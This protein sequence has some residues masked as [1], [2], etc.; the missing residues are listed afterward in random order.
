[1]HA[2]KFSGVS[3]FWFWKARSCHF[4]N[5]LEPP[6]RKTVSAARAA[7]RASLWN[8]SGLFFQTTRSL[9]GPYLSLTSWMLAST[10]LQNGHWKSLKSTSVTGASRLPHVGS[11]DEMGTAASSSL[12][13]PPSS[14]ASAVMPARAP[15]D[16]SI[17]HISIPPAKND[18]RKPTMAVPFCIINSSS[19]GA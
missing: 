19:D 10:L 15:L 9:S 4:Q 1:A 14:N 5:A 7:G 12:Q 8:G 16:R 3:D 13:V 18:R 11:F 6:S 17:P 2:S